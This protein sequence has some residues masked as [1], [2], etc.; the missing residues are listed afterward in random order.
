MELGEAQA[1]LAALQ[2]S[3]QL[4]RATLDAT[5]DG[6]LSINLADGSLH[7]NTRFVEIWGIPK[8]RLAELTPDGLVEF[9]ATRALDPAA[10][11]AQVARRRR[12]PDNEELNLVALSD[13]RVIE[14]HA[15]AQRVNG[16]C[17]GTVITYRDVTERLR[18]EEK[19]LFNHRVLENSG[20]MLW[21]DGDS[22]TLTYANPAACRHLGCRLEQLLG[23]AVRDFDSFFETDEWKAMAQ[24]LRHGEQVNLSRQHRRRD[25]SLRDADI[26]VGM[27]QD[28]ERKIY[29]ASLKDV[30]QQRKAERETRRQQATL[31]LLI[32][33]IPDPV[34]YKDRQGRYLGCNEAYRMTFG[35]G[36]ADVRGKGSFDL[37]PRDMAEAITQRDRLAMLT[38]QKQSSE[39]W[40][41]QPDG[42]RLL[43]ETV[44]SPLWNEDGQAQGVLGV[45]RNITERKRIE[46][47]NRRAKDAAEEAVRLKSDFLANMSHEI[48]TPLNAV[49]GLSRQ[50][51]ATELDARQRDY[52]LKVQSS[53][54]HLLELI[55]DILDFSKVEAGRLE[56]ES[57]QFALQEVFDNI[58][59]LVGEKCQSK[60]L[61][62]IF[63]VAPD[64]PATLVGDPLRLG[65]VLLNYANNAVKFTERGEIVISVRVGQVTDTDAQLLFRVRDT[66]IG[67]TPQQTDRLFLGFS[68]AD[69]STTR[70][71]GGTGLG[72]AICKNL[73]RLMG[74][75]VGVESEWGK[76][77][78]FWFSA[79]LGIARAG[80]QAVPTGRAAPAVPALPRPS[81]ADDGLAVLRGA[82]ILVVED[83]EINQQV[84]TELLQSAG[85]VVEVA[86][87]GRAALDLL[88]CRD[89][90]LVFM[91]MQMPVMDGLTATREIRKIERLRKLPVVAV[92]ASVMEQ[93]RRDCL[94][95]GMN[96]FL[97][98]PIEPDQVWQTLRQWVRPTAA[99]PRPEAVPPAADVP[100]Q[101]RLPSG[102][103]GL[104]TAKG[105]SHMMGKPSLYL[106]MLGR[107]RASQRDLP[108]RIR[109]ALQAGDRTLAERL[110]HTLV[111]T[112]GML[113]ATAVAAHAQALELLLREGG[114][115]G[116]VDQAVEALARPLAEL[117]AALQAQ[118]GG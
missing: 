87:H 7:Y 46:E 17:V 110:A 5:G 88:A 97:A 13:G 20:P 34:F 75:E 23:I 71:Y 96:A 37:F 99:Q 12:E 112:A 106:D 16:D 45:C 117:M 47:E 41:D 64:V 63:E 73:A 100:A 6:I 92:T 36:M 72:L 108:E 21:I 113:G 2:Q 32:D 76:G 77:S 19:M 60:G 78:V 116:Q 40:I 44:V 66:G 31:E 95:A 30:T 85:L 22:G 104:D 115:A 56:L 65:Q 43:F 8:D 102:I 27:I 57:A 25:G 35:R 14:R 80:G 52:M 82:R 1:R 109:Q 107:F 62:L 103:A 55:D 70:K 29:I 105:L 91:D 101:P 79:R 28:G 114:T 61:E 50:V 38:L 48:R 93:N 81:P 59:D 9:M 84:V 67:L 54:R 10:L 39:N 26:T 69:T 83:N 94:E 86:E 68:Q 15:T 118:L 111:G 11:R 18:Y 74:G 51:L 24:A 49:I 89:Y 53:G 3:N 4:L 90:D 33:S 58:S 42:R 98:K